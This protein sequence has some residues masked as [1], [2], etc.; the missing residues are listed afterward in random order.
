[1]VTGVTT[2]INYYAKIWAVDD[3]GYEA[4]L[5]VVQIFETPSVLPSPIAVSVTA[6]GG[7]GFVAPAIRQLN[8]PVL[9]SLISPTR[10]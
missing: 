4:T 6:V 5:P 10:K 2:S 8:K 9:N 1:M 3:Y 7:G